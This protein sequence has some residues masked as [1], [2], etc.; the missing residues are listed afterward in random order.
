MKTSWDV[1][2]DFKIEREA[3]R[4]IRLRKT[5]RWLALMFFIN[6]SG[7]L[8]AHFAPS[9]GRMAWRWVKQAESVMRAAGAATPTS[10]Q[11][12]AAE[13]S[14][15]SSGDEDKFVSNFRFAILLIECL[16]V[17][18]GAVMAVHGVFQLRADKASWSSLA[19][20]I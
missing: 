8:A 13:W 14:D 11:S 16:A 6:A 4:R 15:G 7:L 5:V 1:G 2:N 9:V 17:G 20:G 18:V 10:Q 3:Q 19:G 12:S